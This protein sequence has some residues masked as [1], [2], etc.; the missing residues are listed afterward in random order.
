MVNPKFNLDKCYVDSTA[1]SKA[2]E[3]QKAGKKINKSLYYSKETALN[4]SLTYKK[5]YMK[6]NT[7]LKIK[8]IDYDVNSQMVKTRCS[9]SIKLQS[10]LNQIKDRFMND[11][12]EALRDGKLLSHDG[13]KKMMERACG[14]HQDD[15]QRALSFDEIY[16]KFFD[17]KAS[18]VKART[19]H[20]YESLKTVLKKFEKKRKRKI[21]VD[22]INAQ[23]ANEFSVFLFDH[24]GYV[25][26]TVAK[27]LKSIKCFAKFCFDYEFSLNTKYN[28]IKSSE[29]K[30]AIFVLAQ[31]EI[32]RISDLEIESNSLKEI[33]DAFMF[34]YYVACRFQD[35]KNI[36]WKDIVK[37]EKY[38]YLRLYASKNKESQYNDIP[39]LPEAIELLEAR[40]DR[41]SN[42]GRIFQIPSNQK[43][44][45]NLKK[46]AKLAEIE[47]EFTII[48]RQG[49][50]QVK[51][52]KKRSD[53]TTTH[54][55]R[56]SFISNAY[57][58][59]MDLKMISMISNHSSI[60]IME[61]SYLHISKRNVGDALY[62][63]FNS[64]D[65]EK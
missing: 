62:K 13:I 31:N 58:N 52:V 39:L 17:W 18:N 35:L 42:G 34:Q 49:N 22:D 54:C 23:L 2:K 41:K 28:Q 44:N 4:F 15:D 53:L 30:T 27:Y 43:V 19:M 12:Y 46:I 36:E 20:R 25:H 37:D 7:G 16:Q 14:K 38:S 40:I 29:H 57:I 59:G 48:R 10:L 45:V 63:S 24:C 6:V 51:I 55:A 9:N 60:K 3:Q 56:R 50:R 64:K 33:R 61:D 11:F 47:G 1:S 5:K 26:N 8:P 21:E 65:I 32:Q